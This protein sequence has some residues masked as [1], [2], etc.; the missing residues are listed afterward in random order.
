[1]F[2][3]SFSR[4]AFPHKRFPGIRNKLLKNIRKSINRPF[5]V[6][7]YSPQRYISRNL[8][9]E[10]NSLKS[11]RKNYGAFKINFHVQVVNSRFK[12]CLNLDKNCLII[13][14][15]HNKGHIPSFKKKA[16]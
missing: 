6:K 5:S 7:A 11:I 4:S 13:I 1:M 10:L 3:N 14:Y 9:C 2:I 8:M 12:V 16:F 15:N